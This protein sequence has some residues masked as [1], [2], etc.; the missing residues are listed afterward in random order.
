M[1]PP[2]LLSS[3]LSTTFV[4]VA[5]A[6]FGQ[7]LAITSSTASDDLFAMHY[8]LV[9][10]ADGICQTRTTALVPGTTLDVVVVAKGDQVEWKLLERSNT[11]PVRLTNVFR[12]GQHVFAQLDVNII[13]PEGW[14]QPAWTREE[15]T[16]CRSVTTVS[17]T[18]G[19]STDSFTIDK[20]TQSRIV[21]G[22]NG[23]FQ[24]STE[25]KDYRPMILGC[26]EVHA[27]VSAH[28]VPEDRLP[29]IQAYSCMARAAGMCEIVHANG[30]SRY[31]STE[32]DPAA[33]TIVLISKVQY[34]D[35]P[36]FTQWLTFDLVNARRVHYLSSRLSGSNP[37]L[38]FEVWSRGAG[39][40]QPAW[41][42]IDKRCCYARFNWGVE[43][44]ILEHRAVFDLQEEAL[45]VSCVPDGKSIPGTFC[46]GVFPAMADF[47][48]RHTSANI[49]D[50][51]LGVIDPE[52]S[53][54]VA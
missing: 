45:S 46:S 20:P 27:T 11:G 22:P 14:A 29:I 32:T 5:S 7:K 28:D 1:Y 47:A 41:S 4:H 8:H 38:F 50:L 16:C 2:L 36:Y 15:R 17:V 30:Q 18:L 53:P 33:V 35:P 54:R 49:V 43:L 12:F 26:E 6:Y 10:Q 39:P 3:L 40:N 24:L 42:E 19:V 51:P 13:G 23:Y 31:D 21:C 48:C 37:A 25:C 9:A 44:S 34:T 52:A